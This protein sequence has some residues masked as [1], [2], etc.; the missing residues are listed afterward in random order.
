M[1][2]HRFHHHDRDIDS[3]GGRNSCQQRRRLFISA[4]TAKCRLHK[5]FTKLGISS[6]SQ[7]D[8]VLC[9]RQVNVGS[10]PPAGTCVIV[11]CLVRA[12]TARLPRE[13]RIEPGWSTPG[14]DVAG[15]P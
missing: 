8:R 6:R 5:V 14:R 2:E 4:R 9:R 7:L 13:V 10:A 12:P 11:E 15:E 3:T 1:I